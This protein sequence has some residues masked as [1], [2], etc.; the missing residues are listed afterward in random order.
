MKTGKERHLEATTNCGKESSE[1]KMERT[2]HDMSALQSEGCESEESEGGG[3]NAG[4][5]SLRSVATAIPSA[6]PRLSNTYS[7]YSK[8]A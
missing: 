2:G 3:Q 1:I 5:V 4:L 8:Y 7:V 6:A